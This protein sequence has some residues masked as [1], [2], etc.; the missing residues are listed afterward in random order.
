[1]KYLVLVILF[2]KTGLTYCQQIDNTYRNDS[3]N[4]YN[5]TIKEFLHL[6]HKEDKNKDTMYIEQDFKITDSILSVIENVRVIK[7]TESD[8]QAAMKKKKHIVLFRI[9]PLRYGHEKFWVNIVPFSMGFSRKQKKYVVLN[10]GT[11]KVFYKFNGAV[12]VFDKIEQSE[13]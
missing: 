7:L 2:F 4:I 3:S 11:Y 8:I 12:F 10:G 1:M 6:S 9:F 5:K 13:W